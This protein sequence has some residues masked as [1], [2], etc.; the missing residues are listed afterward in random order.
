[1]DQRFGISV[2]NV[3]KKIFKKLKGQK[4]EESRFYQFVLYVIVKN[5]SSKWNS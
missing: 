3:G 1:M 5:L 4:A 2:W